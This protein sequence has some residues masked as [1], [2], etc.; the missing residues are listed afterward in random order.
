MQRSVYFGLETRELSFIRTGLQRLLQNNQQPQQQQQRHRE[1][2]ALIAVT[3]F[4]SSADGHSGPSEGRSKQLLFESKFKISAGVDFFLPFEY[5]TDRSCN[6]EH[7][8]W[9]KEIASKLL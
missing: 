3:D 2:T 1:W 7:L 9:S 5:L 4:D 6:A 8:V